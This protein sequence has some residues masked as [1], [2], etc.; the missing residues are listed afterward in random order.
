MSIRRA[1]LICRVS[2]GIQETI[3]QVEEL[4]V[5]AVAKGY[6]VEPDDVYEDVISGFSKYEDRPAL[7]RLLENIRTKKKTYA[8]VFAMEVSRISRKPEEGQKILLQFSELN[9]PIYVKNISMCTHLEG[10]FDRSG[11]LKRNPMFQI[12]FVLLSEFAATEAEYIRERSISGIRSK[13]KKGY[14]GGGVFKP[15]GYTSKEGMLVVDESERSVVEDIFEYASKGYGISTI[16]RLLNNAGIPVK[17]HKVVQ[18]GTIASRGSGMTKRII[19]TENIKWADGTV[20][21]ILTNSIYKGERKVKTDEKWVDGKKQPVYSI[22]KVPAIIAPEL[23]DMVQKM[24]SEKYNK[25]SSDQRYL[26]LL[27]NLSVCG[28]CGRALAGRFKPDAK[29]PGKAT[30]A[31]YQ[32]SSKRLGYDNCGNVSV[33]IEAIESVVWN[34][35]T[36]SPTVFQYLQS[37]GAQ[38]QSASEMLNKLKVDA[39]F[40]EKSLVDLER[41]KNR[42]K[43]M[44]RK[45]IIGDEEF[46]SEWEKLLKKDESQQNQLS[47]VRKQMTSMSN[48]RMRLSS[49]EAYVETIE[50]MSLDRFQIAQVLSDILDRVVVTSTQKTGIG[51]N[52]LV[53]IYI[54]DLV[55]P[56]TIYM[57][58][59]QRNRNFIDG[60]FDMNS[61]TEIIESTGHNRFLYMAGGMLGDDVLK[62]NNSGVLVS[63]IKSA[64]DYILQRKVKRKE[65]VAGLLKAKDGETV[66]S[67]EYGWVWPALVPFDDG[68]AK[69]R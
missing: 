6:M 29:N 1:A 65:E 59:K 50:K 34:V 62:Y 31:Y 47:R 66:F 11:I 22:V 37:T 21:G 32:C 19:R 49:L 3:R 67:R 61:E 38:L 26:Y 57:I 54:K 58:T 28:K 10:E 60:D 63:D 39:K 35:V 16:T 36:H 55:P 68:N 27:R 45:D 42:L 44:Y 14:A 23:F 5:L 15:Y 48:L 53:S 13:L 24:R 46:Y 43:S 12:V 7:S 56:I 8:M 2:T 18:K 51:V 17:S 52:Y 40:L 33:N 9:T 20:Q 41:E 69:K 25:R 64:V 4:T 30:D